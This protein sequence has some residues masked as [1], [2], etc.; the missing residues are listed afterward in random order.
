MITQE[1][2]FTPAPWKK[3]ISRLESGSLFTSISEQNASFDV[4][5]ICNVCAIDN[6]ERHHQI[7][8]LIV[9]APEMYGILE[10]LEK[11]IE[12]M[13]EYEISSG[14]HARVKAALSKARG[15]A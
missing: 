5:F 9:T 13:G 14:F 8:N 1:P 6:N 11:I 12:Y 10:E 7:V 3:E 2:K 15:E 4:G